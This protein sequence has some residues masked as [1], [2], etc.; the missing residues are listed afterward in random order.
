MT[1]GKFENSRLFQ[2]IRNG[3][4]LFK[5]M[6]KV[7]PVSIVI[8]IIIWIVLRIISKKCS[9]ESKIKQIVDERKNWILGLGS[10]VSILIQMG[11]LSRPIGSEK[12]IK[13]IPFQTPGGS[14]LIFLYALANLVIFIP[15]GILV[16]KV[17]HGVNAWWKIFLV[18][19]VASLCIEVIQYV[20]A[21]GV[22]EVED[23][24]M[25]VA[26]GVVGYVVVRGIKTK[27]HNID[28][29]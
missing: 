3:G 10:Y 27:N 24:I 22:S 23:V 8:T 18:A 28:I 21:C 17:F 11:I 5:E 1:S 4:G 2:T 6:A 25:N 19:F 13:W 20:L 15:F 26:G 12:A 7:L 16:P 29:E 14:N 9:A